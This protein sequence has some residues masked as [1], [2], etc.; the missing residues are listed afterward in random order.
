MPFNL[1]NLLTW[2]RILLIPLFVGIFYFDKSW[3]SAPNRAM[4]SFSD[5]R[6]KPAALGTQLGLILL[7]SGT[8]VAFAV[9]LMR[10]F[11]ERLPK[12]LKKKLKMLFLML[13]WYSLLAVLAVVLE[14]VQRQL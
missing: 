11:F 13:T 7:Y 8:S 5:V 14:L 1:P 3:V 12:N 4:R 6:S 9:L 2:L 10:I